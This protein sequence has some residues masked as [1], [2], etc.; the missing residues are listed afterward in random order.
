MLLMFV[1]KLTRRDCTFF[2]TVSLSE[3]RRCSLE[4]IKLLPFSLWYS[5]FIAKNNVERQ[6]WSRSGHFLAA[7][8]SYVA[9]SKSF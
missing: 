5:R 4:A 3:N 7:D 8:Q 2:K 1:E 6:E 9:S